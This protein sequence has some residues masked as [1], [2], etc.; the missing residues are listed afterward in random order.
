[1]RIKDYAEMFE[2]E[3]DEEFLRNIS[4]RIGEV[5][6][7]RG[8]TQEQ[9][10]VIADAATKEIQR[11]ETMAGLSLRTLRRLSIAL[12]CHIGEFFKRPKTKPPRP[13]RPKK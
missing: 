12:E 6:R 1:M 11:W 5:R 7:Q 9:L 10:G 4:R 3:T 8:L 13:G 2:R